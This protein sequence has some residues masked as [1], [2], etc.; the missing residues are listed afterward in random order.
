MQEGHYA[1]LKAVVQ[2]KRLRPGGQGD[3]G[4]K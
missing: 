1:I 3:H 4:E 2:K